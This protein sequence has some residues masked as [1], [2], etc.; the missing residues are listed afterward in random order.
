MSTTTI[1]I[2]KALTVQG[3]MSSAELTW[4]AETAS[5]SKRIV[6]IGAYKGRSTCALAGNTD[7]LVYSVDI[8]SECGTD[9]WYFDVWRNNTAQFNNVLAINRASIWAAREFATGGM[10]FDLIFID[11]SH[12]QYNV[13][14]DIMAWR[15]LL[16]QGGVFAGHDYGFV[17]WPDV[18][19]VVDEMIPNVQ[20]VDTIWIAPP[21]TA[22]SAP[23]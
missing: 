20:V 7:G 18:K 12:D 1:D 5:R 22:P 13:R 2:A 15:P 6:E 23:S 21:T 16:A 19:R 14:Q 4:L 11:A 3:W 9:G 8:W 10:R 17:H